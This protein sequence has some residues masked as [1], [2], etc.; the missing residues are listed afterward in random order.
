MGSR[1]TV[2]PIPR[3]VSHPLALP[4]TGP[5]FHEPLEINMA[6]LT[7]AE[8]RDHKL[9]LELLSQP[10]LTRDDIET[11][12]HC[13]HEG[14]DTCNTEF[15][16]F[17]TPLELAY[18]FAIECGNN[19]GK[20]TRIIDLCAGIGVLSHA[21][22][23]RYPE[24]EIVCVEQ[25][26]SYVEVGR[27]L[28]PSATWVC[29]DVTDTDTIATLGIF[30]IAVSNPPFG[31]VRSF[32]DKTSPHYTGGE[33][34]YKVIDIASMIASYGVFIVPQLS[35]GFTYSG[36]ITFLLRTTEKY[37]K[38]MADTGIKLEAGCGIDTSY[39]G[40]GHWKGI[41]PVVEVVCA[42]FELVN[43]AAPQS[44]LFGDAA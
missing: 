29:A 41:A 35:S 16:A 9:A 2:S 11:V 5:V 18:D 30:D 36:R 15:G 33:A 32:K 44:D 26:P 13:F 14:A 25:N 31:R 20:G 38:F 3:S 21:I 40:Y 43:R 8:L 39:H 34:E 23:T 6:K 42:D 7:K 1:V 24:A 4:A 22:H 19:T 37:A 10:T 17:F 12:Y 28:L 27:K